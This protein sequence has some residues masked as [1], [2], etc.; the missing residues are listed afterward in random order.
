MMGPPVACTPVPVIVSA[1]VLV[2]QTP[3]V[4]PLAWS[5]LTAVTIEVAPEMATPVG[6]EML[7]KFPVTVCAAASVIL[8]PVLVRLTVAVPVIGALRV[9]LPVEV[10]LTGPLVVDWTPVPATVRAPVLVI[11]IPVCAVACWWPT[12]VM[13]GKAFE[14]PIVVV[15][16][17]VRVDPVTVTP[18]ESVT[19]PASLSRLTALVPAFTAPVRSMFP[20]VFSTVTGPT[21]LAIPVTVSVAIESIRLTLL[22]PVLVALKLP[23][24]FVSAK[25]VPPTETVVSVPV[26]V[27]MA[28]EASMMP[29]VEVRVTLPLPAEI[30]VP[31]KSRSMPTAVLAPTLPV[32]L[33]VV[34]GDTMEP[35]TS[36]P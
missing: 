9:M 11:Q 8:P 30:A 35:S 22:L 16:E 18:P 10:R 20:A 24:A 1:P 5:W 4:P 14:T 7:S 17:A 34:L 23:T 2:T 15:A 29:P 28:G 26:V 32:T 36:T 6:A 27:M 3:T 19:A 31:E 25:K 33:T 21:V 13:S 12:A